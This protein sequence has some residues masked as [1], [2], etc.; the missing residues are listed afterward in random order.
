VPERRDEL[1]K[2]NRIDNL[3]VHHE[4]PSARGLQAAPILNSQAQ[5][6]LI[7]KVKSQYDLRVFDSP[8]WILS[9]GERRLGAGHPRET[10][11]I[12]HMGVQQP[13]AFRASSIRVSKTP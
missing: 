2:T 5:D 12:S 10:V 11:E 13:P 9:R 3:L 6:R 7:A 1:I 8:A 4:R